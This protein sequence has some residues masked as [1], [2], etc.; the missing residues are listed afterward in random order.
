VQGGKGRRGRAQRQGRGREGGEGKRG[1]GEEWMEAVSDRT[2][3]G[4]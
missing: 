2:A 3:H 4:K 1:A